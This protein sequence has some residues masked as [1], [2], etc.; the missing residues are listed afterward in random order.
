MN[1]KFKEILTEINPEIFDNPNAHLV[2]D[3]I[4]ESF[5]IMTIIGECE[6]AFDIDFDPA[7]ILPEN[8][9]SPEKIWSLIE[10]YQNE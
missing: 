1:E 3:G 7:D 5:D 6:E 4:I 10:K 8:F 9:S 2:E